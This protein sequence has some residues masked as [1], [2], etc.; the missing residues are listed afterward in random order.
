MIKK[1]PYSFTSQFELFPTPWE[2]L[3]SITMQQANLLF[4]KGY[5]SFDPTAHSELHRFEIDEMWFLKKLFYDSGLPEVYVLTMFA[6]LQKPY[7]YS[8]RDIYWDFEDLCWKKFNPIVLEMN[9]FSLRYDFIEAQPG[10]IKEFET[11]ELEELRE[12]VDEEIRERSE[13]DSPTFCFDPNIS[14]N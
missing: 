6:Q 12:L 7:Y 3:Y 8:L 11:E 13:T 5:L 1:I 9:R 2:K 10:I 4:Q 14:K